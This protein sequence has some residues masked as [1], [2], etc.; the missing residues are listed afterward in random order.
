MQLSDKALLE[1]IYQKEENAF[2]ELYKRY[3]RLF[4]NLAYTYTGDKESSADIVQHFW[5]SIWTKPEAIKANEDD[6]A[7]SFLYK[8]FSFFVNTY[9]RSLYAQQKN[10]SDCNVDQVE[11]EISYT[12]IMEELQVK[13]IHLL[14]DKAIEEMPQ[15]TR[16]IFIR[17][18]K[19]DY[20]Q[21]ETA[22]SLSIS[23]QMVRNRYNWAMSLIRKRLKSNHQL[24]IYIPLLSFLMNFLKR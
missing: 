23:E 10:I 2:N 11:N 9:Y 20:S 17:R 1:A 19:E 18:W 6:S 24:D 21:Q 12:H 8:H 3:K 14:I 22:H 15:M 16:Q 4:Y 5:I 7:K 13:E